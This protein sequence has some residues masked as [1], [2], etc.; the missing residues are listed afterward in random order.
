MQG[1]G[2]VYLYCRQGAREVSRQLPPHDCR[3]TCES[4][5]PARL[6]PCDCAPRMRTLVSASFAPPTAPEK[7]VMKR[8][9][10]SWLRCACSPAPKRSCAGA[11][12]WTASSDLAC[13]AYK[14][15]C[16]VTMASIGAVWHASEGLS[17]SPPLAMGTKSRQCPVTPAGGQCGLTL[18]EPL[19]VDL[20]QG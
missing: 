7:L 1:C 4:Q 3:H 20:R 11:C 17:A 5:P 15:A 18:L 8:G 14:H 10:K 13:A 9:S 16:N 12:G 2:K 6:P 19:F